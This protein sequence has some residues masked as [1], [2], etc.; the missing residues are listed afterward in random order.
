MLYTLAA[1][2]VLAVFIAFNTYA[3]S[4]VEGTFFFPTYSGGTIIV[5]TLT[6]IIFFKDKFTTK[7]V[8]SLIIG[9]VA[10][11]LMNF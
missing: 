5:S 9:V 2:V 10:I 1:G 4:I 3:H 7:Q 11:V 6:G 8:L